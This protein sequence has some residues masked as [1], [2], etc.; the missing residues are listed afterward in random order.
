[1]APKT[2]IILELI[3]KLNKKQFQLLADYSQYV[4]IIC[5]NPIKIRIR[6]SCQ[7]YRDRF[8]KGIG[9]VFIVI[10]ETKGR[11]FNWRPQI[12]TVAV[13]RNV[14]IHT[15]IRTL[16]VTET[17]FEAPTIGISHFFVP[18]GDE[19]GFFI[20]IFVP[21]FAAIHVIGP[22]TALGTRLRRALSNVSVAAPFLQTC[23]TETMTAFGQNAK[24]LVS[25]TRFGFHLFETDAA[26]HGVFRRTGFD[27]I[28]RSAQ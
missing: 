22:C 26:G 10:K 6:I 11:A 27:T 16:T 9:K 17:I 24:D 18:F 19:S 21:N 1:M 7:R 14:P 5:I 4:H 25:T 2:N 28:V 15:L 12:H 8:G 23:E 3:K 20:F 13:D